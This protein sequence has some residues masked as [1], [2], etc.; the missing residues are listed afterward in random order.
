MEEAGGLIGE[1]AADEKRKG[2]HRLAEMLGSSSERQ[3]EHLARRPR[4]TLHSVRDS[5]R[6]HGLDALPEQEEVAMYNPPR[7]DI[8]PPIEN[9]SG[10]HSIAMD[11]ALPVNIPNPEVSTHSTRHDLALPPREEPQRSIHTQNVSPQKVNHGYEEIEISPETKSKIIW[12]VLGGGLFIV[13]LF[14][15]IILMTS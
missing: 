2:E 10:V 3:K 7:N 6:S 14:I 11:N 9:L 4:C 13:V 5:L 12:V 1:V 8:A 15:A